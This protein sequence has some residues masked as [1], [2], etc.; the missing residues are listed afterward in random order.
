V[1]LSYSLSREEFSAGV[2]AL[3]SRIHKTDGYILFEKKIR[4]VFGLYYM[5]I[6]FFFAVFFLIFTDYAIEIY[7]L[8]IIT[9]SLE[10]IMRQFLK[11]LGSRIY[12]VTFEHGHHEDL[13]V[14]FDEDTISCTGPSYRREWDSKSIQYLHNLPDVFV[15]Q[16]K[17]FEILTIPKRAFGS[18][19]MTSKWLG[20]VT[21]CIS[22]R[23]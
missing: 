16:F 17:G 9:I 8:F 1:H 13:D 7:I 20:I 10:I 14:S 5:A 22:V 2:A 15:V 19:E 6:I 3:T 21:R 4:I 23:S 12:S 18:D 11:R